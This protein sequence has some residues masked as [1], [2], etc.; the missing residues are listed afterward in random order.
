MKFR[1]FKYH[2]RQG[3]IGLLKNR[4]MSV[5]SIATVAACAIIFVVS[6]CIVLNLDYILEQLEDTIGIS[7]FLGDDLTDE[8]VKDI[9]NSIEKIGHVSDVVYLSQKDALK[10]AEETWQ[11]SGML[12]GLEEDNPFP[13]SFDISLDGVKYQKEVVTELENLQREYEIKIVSEK[14]E[15]EFDENNKRDG[16]TREEYKAAKLSEIDT[17]NYENIGIE[18]IT[19]AQKESEVLVTINTVLRVMSII[20]IIIMGMISVSIIMN[21]IK[22]TVFIRK[23]EINIMKY[24]GA[25]DW[26]I[27]WPFIVEGIMIGLLGSLIPCLLCWVGYDNTINIAY[28]KIIVLQDLVK[29]K[30]GS[31]IFMFIMPVTLFLGTF[32]GAAGSISSIR[33]HLNV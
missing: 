26:F 29:F 31:E 25:T 20:L 13:R 32:L 2:I 23:N 7:V 8:Q 19:H 1:T 18:K 9:Q 4:L 14:A 24:I 12:D 3:F 27:R 28:E 21:T 5:A 6:F 10:W 11:N 22:L 33:K 30:T 16:V 17:V 15:N